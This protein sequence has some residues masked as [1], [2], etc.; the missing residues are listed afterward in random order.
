MPFSIIAFSF[1]DVPHSCRKCC[2]QRIEIEKQLERDT[3]E[4]KQ[5]KIDL[6]QTAIAATAD[7][8]PT[9]YFLEVS[10]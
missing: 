1:E 6:A 9:Q 8:F 7:H 4:L 3:S 2:K 5:A 10:E